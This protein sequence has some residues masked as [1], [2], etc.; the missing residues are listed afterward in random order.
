MIQ[1]SPGMQR[2]LVES[3]CLNSFSMFRKK[4]A[5]IF[6][7]YVVPFRVPWVQPAAGVSRLRRERAVGL[8]PPETLPA[9]FGLWP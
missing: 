6:H 8:P 2:G 1:H 7:E 9:A 3:L 4:T 5:A